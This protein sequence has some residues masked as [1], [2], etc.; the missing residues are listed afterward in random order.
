MDY[1]TVE[2]L[3]D[4]ELQRLV[5]LAT[6]TRLTRK[7]LQEMSLDELVKA[8]DAARLLRNTEAD[9][10]VRDVLNN[11]I[12][13]IDQECRRRNAVNPQRIVGRLDIGSPVKELTHG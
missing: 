9:A 7:T 5:A 2:S 10:G 8:T 6:Y 12:V 3:T 1:A 11:A 4:D 13:D